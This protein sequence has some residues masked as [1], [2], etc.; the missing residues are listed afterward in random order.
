MI[1]SSLLLRIV[2]ICILPCLNGA[3]CTGPY[4]CGCLAGYTGSRC[5]T[6]NIPCPNLISTLDCTYSVLCRL[7]LSTYKG[8]CVCSCVWQALPQWWSLLPAQQMSVSL[9]LLAPLLFHT[10]TT[11]HNVISHTV[12]R[13]DSV[14]RIHSSTFAYVRLHSSSSDEQ[15]FARLVLCSCVTVNCALIII[16]LLLDYLR[17]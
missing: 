14:I 3:K 13:V 10:A 5:E 8:L 17:V 16:D 6:R 1:A 4:Q 15:L 9:W 7:L 11:Q 12:G 2:A